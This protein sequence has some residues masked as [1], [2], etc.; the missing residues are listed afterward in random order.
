ML[1]EP[2]HLD[3]KRAANL[4]SGTHAITAAYVTDLVRLCT[5]FSR[6]KAKTD[7]FDFDLKLLF[8]IERRYLSG[9]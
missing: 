4:Q 7:E 1:E 5:Y 2:F 6:S 3:A 9:V 8:T